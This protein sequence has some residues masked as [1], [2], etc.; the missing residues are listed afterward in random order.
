MNIEKFNKTKLFTILLS[1]EHLI[2]FSDGLPSVDCSMKDAITII[3]N[4]K[5]KTIIEMKERIVDFIVVNTSPWTSE[6][7]PDPTALIVLLE[8]NLIVIDLKTDGYPQ[9]NHHHPINLHE[10]P[11]T[12][13]QY[14]V[15]PNQSI[16]R[17]LIEL[18]EKNNSSK[19]MNQTAQSVNMGN[20]GGATTSVP[21]YSQLVNYL[22]I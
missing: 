9:F 22:I 11:L 5:I 4:N 3:K 1:S 13:C 20:V 15:E 8:N 21:F 2:I 14:I 7:P 19:Q 10:S 12:L 6:S 18:K 16:F 17:N